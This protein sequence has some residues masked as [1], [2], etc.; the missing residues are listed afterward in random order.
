MNKTPQKGGW[1][2]EKLGLKTNPFVFFWSAGLISVFVMATLWKREVMLEFF[3]SVQ[4][5]IAHSAGWF[6]I[7]TINILLVFCIYLGFSKYK[8]IR[9][10]GD[11]A[12][13]EFSFWSWFAMLFNAGIGL[14]LMFYSVAEP[15]LHFAHPP[16]GEAGT[17]GAAQNAMGI[18]FMHWGIH[19]WAVY[20]IVG[21]AVAFFAYNRGLPLSI[22]S[23][24]H[25]I[26]GDR[27]YGRIGDVIDIIAV[28]ATLFG[29]ATTLGLG[30]KHINA[31]LNYL[32]G[33][34]QEPW[35]QVVLVLVIT[36]FATV[37]VVMGLQS[38]IRRLSVLSTWLAIVLMVFMLVVGPTLFLLDMFVQN[39]GFYLQ[40][41]PSMGTWSE[42][43]KTTNWQD[44]WTIF[45][46]GWWFA[47]APFVGIF[48][49]RIS[50]G[51]TIGQFIF[52]V[53]LAPTLAVFVWI[54]IFGGTALHQEL[55]GPG[56][57]VAAV[58]A[59]ISTSLYVLLERFP[60]AGFSS[61]FVVGAGVIFFVTSSD[62]GSLVV[63]FITTGGKHN[64]PVKQRI[65]WALM[66][67]FVAGVLLLGGGLVALQTGSLATGLPVAVVLLFVCYGLKKGFDKELAEEH[68]PR[69]AEVKDIMEE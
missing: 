39:L 20:A 62:S 67:G 60:L 22:R 48:I 6:Y 40:K 16:Y 21:L 49:A 59:N 19:G 35:I 18:T 11:Q 32:T 63:D 50:R 65:F 9:I 45:Y 1:L 56:G 55:F 23:V 37:S 12:R 52:G 10:G 28:V 46:W 30:I 34:P 29:L 24:F 68:P 69:T 13:P 25:P 26:I 61:A 27:I 38:G 42:V 33:L 17:I 64:P 14:A 36:L 66:E 47:W 58:D 3:T 31:G 54:T 7:L 41:L 43:Y 44:G 53:L 57:I 8:H 5:G 51:R 15:I 4:T 2:E